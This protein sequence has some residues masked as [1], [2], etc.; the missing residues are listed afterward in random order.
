ME[1]ENLSCSQPHGEWH[2]VASDPHPCSG[3]GTSYLHLGSSLPSSAS[4]VELPPEKL[5]GQSLPLG[6]S[7]A[8][9]YGPRVPQSRSFRVLGVQAVV[10]VNWSSPRCANPSYF[11]F[12]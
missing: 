5:L 2:P 1:L 12:P 4:L 10:P 11:V 3:R 7:L 8:N 9:S 6:L